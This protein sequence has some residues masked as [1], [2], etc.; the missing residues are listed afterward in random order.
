M[1]EWANNWFYEQSI[2]IISQSG[3]V[4]FIP[5]SIASINTKLRGKTLPKEETDVVKK[6]IC[7]IRNLELNK[8]MTIRSYI[9]EELIDFLEPILSDDE[10]FRV[11]LNQKNS[12]EFEFY[13]DDEFMLAGYTISFMIASGVGEIVDIS[14]YYKDQQIKNILERDKNKD[15]LTI[16][17]FSDGQ[18]LVILFQEDEINLLLGTIQFNN[19][20]MF[21]YGECVDILE[22]K[23]DSLYDSHELVRINA[24]DWQDYFGDDDCIKNDESDETDEEDEEDEYEE[25][26]DEEY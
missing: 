15:I 25:Y 21:R 3:S 10:I 18:Q 9:Y 8:I 11:K 22:W 7:G 16:V 26:D 24:N 4:T 12:N 1:F 23:H 19:K 20:V 14:H 6:L 17:T 2:E 5:L 13:A